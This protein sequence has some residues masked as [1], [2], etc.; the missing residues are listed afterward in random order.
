MQSTAFGRTDIGC[1]RDNNQDAII[2]DDSLGLYIVCDGMGGYEGGEVASSLA[3]E[4][5][6]NYVREHQRQFAL[7]IKTGVMAK[8]LPM[9]VVDAIKRANDKVCLHCASN[10]VDEKMATTLTL[11]LVHD[12]HVVIGHSG[13][14]RSYR[15][16]EKLVLLTDHHTMGEEL[17]AHGWDED[18]CR[19]YDNV[20]TQVVGRIPFDEPDV[21][22]LA[23]DRE[24]KFMLCSDGLS[25]FLVGP[26]VDEVLRAVNRKAMADGMIELAL[27]GGGPD[28]ISAIVVEVMP[29]S[30]VQRADAVSHALL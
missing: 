17:R 24:M 28:N 27:A 21:I 23:V 7:M 18:E 8:W 6:V 14:S 4:T 25:P 13:D 2:A 3:I 30:I 15:I 19:R 9:F 22:T 5:V 29:K 12:D 16:D 11:I 20:L 1:K 26:E 10:P